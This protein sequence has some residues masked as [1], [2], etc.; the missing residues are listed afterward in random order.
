MN[1]ENHEEHKLA[2]KFEYKEWERLFKYVKPYKNHLIML[3]IAAVLTAFFDSFFPRMTQFAIEIFIDNKTTTGVSLFALAFVFLALMQGFFS[4]MYAK[5]GITIEMLVGKDMREDLF[6]HTQTLSLDYFNRTPVGFILARIMQDTNSL[7][8]L[9]SWV[10]SD[11]VFNISY[12]TFAL[13]NMFS[14]NANL[15]FAVI[16]VLPITYKITDYFQK[17]LLIQNRIVRTQNSVITGAYNEYITGATAIKELDIKDSINNSFKKQNQDLK[18]K[19]LVFKSIEAMFFPIVMIFS[20]IIISI[21]LG[22]GSHLVFNRK[23]DVAE[24]SVFV[25]YSLV[26]TDP[27]EKII[28]AFTRVISLQAN[29]ER[30]NRLIDTKPLVKDREDVVE[31]YGDIYNP[32]TESWEEIKGDIEF[33][34]VSFKYPGTKT[35]VLK[36]FNLKVPAGS[37][38]AIV[39][40]TGAGKSTL[41]NLVCRFFEPTS[42]SI[43]IDG[44]DYKDRSLL[45]LQ[46]NLSYVL[47]TP[48]LFSGSIEDNIRYSKPKASFEEIE[49]A[50]KRAFAHPF[51][52]KFKDGYKTQIGEGGDKLSIGQKQLVSIARAILADGKILVM[53]E[54]TSSVDTHTEQMIN[55]MSGD[56]MK[57]KT[58][59]IIAHRLSTIK[60]ADVI[61]V[62]E[63]G[64]IVE[65]GTHKELLKSEGV[66]Y[67]MYTGQWEEEKQS[68]FF[69]KLNKPL[70]N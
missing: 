27:I 59:F 6:S 14:I 3:L 7:G 22:Y 32:K 33:C 57:N 25:S 15:A 53:D 49:N 12:I 38:V 39:G 11:F 28:K 21:V 41:V 24:L 18:E 55:S 19:S 54:A 13:V 40:H 17:K 69:N 10:I 61:L 67:E 4:I 9:F 48:H 16:L 35:Y 62:V 44:I 56:L 64:K 43:L 51:I 37:S 63:N 68:D 47:Q 29:V 50:S 46:N 36:N 30:V 66:Y 34:D 8:S 1:V 20:G 5:R 70:Q 52:E 58:T 26:L 2:S 31:H 23:L 42:G 45:W 60:N 65:R